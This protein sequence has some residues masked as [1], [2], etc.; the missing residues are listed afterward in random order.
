M[1]IAVSLLVLTTWLGFYV[2]KDAQREIRSLEIEALAHQEEKK[3]F[4][5]NRI[6]A[7]KS[8]SGEM[9][10]LECGETFEPS[11]VTCFCTSW[12]LA[13]WTAVI[14]DEDD[15]TCTYVR[16]KQPSTL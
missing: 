2:L 8:G 16:P 15:E 4:N 12:C 7:C 13:D 9:V 11:F 10:Y 1:R 6:Q 5:R 14:T 3:I